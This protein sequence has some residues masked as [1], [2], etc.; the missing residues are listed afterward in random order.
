MR[1]GCL[2]ALLLCFLLA[3]PVKANTQAQYREQLEAGGAADLAQQLPANAQELMKE[4]GLDLAAPESF[5]SLSGE[6]LMESLGTLL[7]QQ[8]LGPLSTA[9]SLMA[10]VVLAGLF[11]G[12]GS[13]VSTSDLRQTYHTVTVLGAT[14]LL[15]T[16]LAGLLQTVWQAVESVTVFLYSYIPVYAAIIGVSGGGTSALSYQST[17]LATAELLAT[18]LRTVVWPCL[19]VALALGCIGAVTEGFRLDAISNAVHKLIL[20]GMGLFSSVFTW[21]LSTQ[22]MVARAGDTL[23]SRAMKFSLSSFVPVVGGALSEA[24]STVLGCAGLLRSTVGVFGVAAVILTVLPPLVG[25]VCWSLCLQV[26]GVAAGLFRLSALESLFRAVSGAVRVLIAVMAMLALLM[27][28]ST[29]VVAF[30]GKGV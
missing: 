23:G 1:R 9:A 27:V 25:C 8:S 12:Y 6:R 5:T 11:S 13:A 18:L 15:L 3:L 30:V 16:P 21:V 2:A 29:S 28:V 26:S 7:R 17:L 24:Y 20:W 4:L 19:T 22:Q 14:G 10:V